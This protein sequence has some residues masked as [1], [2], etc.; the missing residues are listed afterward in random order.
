M[1]RSTQGL[2]CPVCNQNTTDSV[3]A[4]EYEG[5]LF[6]FCCPYCRSQ[7]LEECEAEFLQAASKKEQIGLEQ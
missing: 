4:V 2:K 6:A 7:F 5:E 1:N 3:L